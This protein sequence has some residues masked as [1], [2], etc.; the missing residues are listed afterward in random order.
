MTAAKTLGQG[1]L[2][3]IPAGAQYAV[4]RCEAQAVRW[5]D[6][7]VTTPTATLGMPMAVADAPMVFTSNLGAL[8]FIAQVSGAIL[9][10]AFYKTANTLF[11][12]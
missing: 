1:T 6:D 4:V 12:E 2:G 8:L 10:V 9:D 7:G 3:A 11:P 5:T